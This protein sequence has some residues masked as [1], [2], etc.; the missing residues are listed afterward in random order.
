[1]NKKNILSQ[2]DLFVTI[3]VTVVGSAAFTYPRKL[4]EVIGS[5]GWIVIILS[6]LIVLPFLYIIYKAIEINEYRR[7][8]EMLQRNFGKFLGNAIA[9]YIVLAGMFI[10]AIEIRTFAE[11][12]KM[13]LLNRTPTEF[14]ILAMFLVGGFL[15]RGEVESVIKFNEIAFWLMFV[16][17]LTGI[18]FVLKGSDFTNILPIFVHE[19]L[20]YIK[21]VRVSVFSFLGFG[22]LY[23]IIPMVRNKRSIIRVTFKSL[24]FI[25]AF[26][27]IITLSALFVFSKEYNSQLLWPTISM[28]ST[29]DMPGTFIERWEG[30]VMT[31]W[32]IFYFTTYVNVYYFSSEIIRDVFKLEDVKVSLVLIT[33]VIYIL[34]LYP[35]N[36]AE[37]YSIQDRITPYTDPV[38]IGILPIVLL[39]TGFA[40]A[41]R[42]KDET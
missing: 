11:V 34:S 6:A 41:R 30:I 24:A 33:P 40:K 14:I 38:I 37:V 18:P 16:P 39:I 15:V 3:V 12:I 31:F 2:Y 10:M 4:S 22:I 32:I 26:Y 27:I 5:E 1:M 25:S 19:P 9:L 17:V 42:V 36:I 7:L 23:M 28:F 29:V 35:E 21:A 20:E 13:Y 8:V